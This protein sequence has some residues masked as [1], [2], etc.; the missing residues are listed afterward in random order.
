VDT[1]VE[2]TPIKQI[3]YQALSWYVFLMKQTLGSVVSFIEQASFGSGG[4]NGPASAGLLRMEQSMKI[5][6]FILFAIAAVAL[7]SAPE[8]L[9]ENPFDENARPS[10]VSFDNPPR[11][12][13]DGPT[14]KGLEV[15]KTFTRQV[16]ASLDGVFELN[17]VYPGSKYRDGSPSEYPVG[18]VHEAPRGTGHWA[19]MWTR[20]V[21]TFFREL[22]MWGYFEHA[23][24]TASVL[25]D[26]V[27]K[28]SDG[29]HTYPEQLG[30][31]PS[32]GHELDGT[33]PIV[34]GLIML[35]QRLPDDDPVR[36]KI[37]AFLHDDSSPLLYICMR[38]EKEPLIPGT[39]EFGPGCFLNG[40]YYN[41]VQ[42]NLCR[43]TLLA[44]ADFEEEAGDPQRGQ[45]YLD[46]AQK[47][48]AEMLKH[49]VDPKDGSWIWCISP[50]TLKP[51]PA[52]IDAPVNKG[53]GLINGVGCML[54]DVVGLEPLL[55]DWAGNQACE[56]TFQKLYQTETRKTYFDEIGI[57]TQFDPPFRNGQNTSPSYGQGYAL[58]YML[59]TDKTEMAG[60]AV[61][62]LTRV[63]NQGSHPEWFVEQMNY[64]FQ[65]GG[66]FLN[67]VNVSEPI[68]AARLIVGVDDT[69]LDEVRILPR[70]VGAVRSIHV[71]NWPI[72]S[73]SGV[74]RIDFLL[75]DS[76]ASR[77]TLK[78]TSGEPI[79]Q[80]AVRLPVKSGWEWHRANNV[81][82]LDLKN[83]ER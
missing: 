69:D 68:K 48:S 37:Y 13:F 24:L 54:S 22:V 70:P 47:L 42:N 61:D 30:K 71:E 20:G 44:G 81:T 43:L 82:R 49:L 11:L 19:T 40:S 18:T 1:L 83:K 41:V 72:R 36:D 79:P 27:E 29:Y 62:W 74:S 35:W 52:V 9:G 64:P 3:H 6:L 51:D 53:A 2:T 67:L 25:I 77:F 80:L 59:A 15:A 21:G 26:L 39:G 8:A 31:E 63:T 73:V 55:I 34:I 4:A 33:C 10:L 65:K 60:K 45:R 50:S 32:S 5:R 23:K 28:N 76:G 17:Y 66:Y 78:V 7:S 75:D 14:V 56:A 57:W 38:L 12:S 58:Q 46:K 16:N